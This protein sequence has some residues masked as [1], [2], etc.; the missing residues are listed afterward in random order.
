[1]QLAVQVAA[2]AS[3]WTNVLPAL[4]NQGVMHYWRG[5][6]SAAH[7]VL[8]QARAH[9]ERLY[10][11]SG[12]GIKIDIHLG[13][14]L[15][16]LGRVDEAQGMLEGALAEMQRWPDN[17]YRRTECLLTDNHLA[18]MF[19]AL[20]RAD[21]AAQVLAH[22]AS[23]VADRFYGRR[24]TLRLRWQRLFGSVD[25]VLVTELEAV[26]ARVPSPF[27]RGLM[28]LELGRQQ[29]PPAAAAAC[30]ALYHS[31]V[32]VQRPGLQLHAAALAAQACARA[33]NAPDAQHWVC[34]RP[35]L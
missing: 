32:A 4:S 11:S 23:G 13:A 14:V 10:G 16:E 33:G 30:E 2:A 28:T 24:L 3:D 29:P 9:R 15:Y 27:N 8:A 12:S 19:M 35:R 7:A 5:E 20:G 17:E 26:A 31:P 22:D 6:Y 18:Q 1:V 25:P 34:G 21:A